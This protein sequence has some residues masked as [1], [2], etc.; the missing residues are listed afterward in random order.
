MPWIDKFWNKNPLLAYLRPSSASPILNFAATRAKERMDLE[1]D[2]DQEKPEL[3]S[4]D[5]LSR[6]IEAQL[7]DPQVPEW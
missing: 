4:R 6:F 3:N 1:K 5:F 7:K 2:P